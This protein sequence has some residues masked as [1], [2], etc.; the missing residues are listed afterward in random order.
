M[1][2][3]RKLTAEASAGHGCMTLAELSAF[4]RACVEAEVPMESTLTVR[5]K[6]LTGRLTRVETADPR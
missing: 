1:P 6:G 4:L 2:V 3:T 5:V